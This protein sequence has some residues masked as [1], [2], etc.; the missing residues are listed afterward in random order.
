MDIAGSKVKPPAN[1]GAKPGCD[2]AL[3]KTMAQGVAAR[4]PNSAVLKTGGQAELDKIVDLVQKGI[5]KDPRPVDVGSI[6]ITGYS[7][8]FEAENNPNLDEQHAKAVQAYLAQKGFEPKLMF[9]EGEDT[10]VPMLVT[11]FCAD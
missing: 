6:I 3:L 5:K 7:D 4:D 8:R 9:W 10:R 11:E 1:P 2:N